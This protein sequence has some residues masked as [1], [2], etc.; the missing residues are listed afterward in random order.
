MYINVTYANVHSCFDRSSYKTLIFRKSKQIV[1]CFFFTRVILFYEHALSQKEGNQIQ[2]WSGG[3]RTYKCSEPSSAVYP[4]PAARSPFASRQKPHNVTS[5]QVY[6]PSSTKT[7][8]KWRRF[9]EDLDRVITAVPRADI[10]VVLERRNR[11][12]CLP[13]MGRNCYSG[14]HNRSLTGSNQGMDERMN[15]SLHCRQCHQREKPCV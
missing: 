2:V 11:P 4:F 5:S 7:T 6:V 13:A 14:Q 10:F 12:R 1:C 15:L 3:P 8:E 9:Y